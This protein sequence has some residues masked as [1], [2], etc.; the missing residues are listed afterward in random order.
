MCVRESSDDKSEEFIEFKADTTS[1]RKLLDSVSR[2]GIL[3]S[4]PPLIIIISEKTRFCNKK[5]T[6]IMAMVYKNKNN[7]GQY[8]KKRIR[9]AGDA[10]ET[11]LKG[12]SRF[13]LNIILGPS[14]AYLAPFSFTFRRASIRSANLDFGEMAC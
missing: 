5:K 14:A 11:K 1:S 7:S 13:R 4:P 6:S 10:A 12:E 8:S 2:L 3:V 9:R